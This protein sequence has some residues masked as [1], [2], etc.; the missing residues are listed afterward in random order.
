[1][2]DG[3]CGR[4]Q[5]LYEVEKGAELDC[6]EMWACEKHVRSSRRIREHVSESAC[7]GKGVDIGLFHACNILGNVPM[8]KA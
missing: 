8:E 7:V 4:A 1:M 5:K 6:V 3:G 2:A